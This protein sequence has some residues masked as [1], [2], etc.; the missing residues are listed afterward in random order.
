MP[1]RL[2]VLIG[3]LLLI[4]SNANAGL[5]QITFDGQLD[6]VGG[7]DVYSLDGASFMYAILYSTDTIPTTTD[8]G[9]V[10]GQPL[11]TSK[12]PMLSAI[13]FSNRPNDAPDNGALIGNSQAEIFNWSDAFGHTGV[14]DFMA[15]SG[16]N[17]ISL[18]FVG[19]QGPTAI[20][21]D[22]GPNTFFADTDPVLRL[23]I[24]SASDIH[25]VTGDGIFTAGTFGNLIAQYYWTDVS[26]SAVRSVPEPETLALMLAG[27]IAIA[28]V[29]RSR[30]VSKMRVCSQ[31]TSER[32]IARPP[33]S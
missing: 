23:P 2:L 10:S 30:A 1:S 16:L 8:S 6:L 26:T 11:S 33:Y 28:R 12:F 20:G 21:I 22:L 9:P 19:L 31:A 17:L 7:T 32:A 13:A 3:P 15:F 5:V 18:G 4:A 24:L 14:H 27:L 25:A 29:R